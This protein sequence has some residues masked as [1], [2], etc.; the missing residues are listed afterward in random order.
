MP[1]PGAGGV[2]ALPAAPFA[3]LRLVCFAN[4]RGRRRGAGGRGKEDPRCGAGPTGQEG[5]PMP[6]AATAQPGVPASEG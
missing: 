2:R 4:V 1:P 5:P 3:S 6:P